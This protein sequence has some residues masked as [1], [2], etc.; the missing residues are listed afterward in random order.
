MELQEARDLIKAADE[1]MAAAFVRRMEAV[2]EIAAYK[3][4]HGLPIEDKAQE[5]RVLEGR[6]K[7]IED[8]ALLPYYQRF[9][10]GTMALSKDWQRE[11]IEAD[12]SK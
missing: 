1:E 5:A 8:P 9:L 2:R 6:S 4:A 11:R 12:E 10:R 3:R 7:L